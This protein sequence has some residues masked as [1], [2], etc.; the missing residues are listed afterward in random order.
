MSSK[1]A[2]K[3]NNATAVKDK[4]GNY[5]LILPAIILGYIPLIIHTYQYDPG[6][7]E[8]S[9]FDSGQVVD[10]YLASKMFIYIP[11]GLVM[12]CIFFLYK[13]IREEKFVFDKMLIPLY[14]YAAFVL[15]SGF[16]SPYKMQAWGGSFE[17][18]ESVPV[19]LIY[20]F[21]AIYVYS[22]A[23]SKAD[24]NLLWKVASPGIFIE[25]LISALQYFDLD[26]FKTSFAKHLYLSPIYWSQ[27]DTMT[28]GQYRTSYGT[29]Y[30]PDFLPA[31]HAVVISLA[32]AAFFMVEKP[33]DE[34]QAALSGKGGFMTEKRRY[35]FERIYNAVILGL[36]IISLIGSDTASGKIVLVVVVLV[37]IVGELITDVKHVV[38]LLV[39][40]AL[41]I[42]A[43][44]GAAASPTAIGE[45]LRPY[46]FG[47]DYIN[48]VYM[49]AMHNNKDDVDFEISCFDKIYTFHSTFSP[50]TGAV[51]LTCDEP[52]GSNMVIGALPENPAVI[53][54]QST[55]NENFIVDVAPYYSPQQVDALGN[56]T[57]PSYGGISITLG[58]KYWYFVLTENGYMYYTF[59]D[60]LE[61]FPN[62]V[63]Y[64][65]FFD[66]DLLHHRGSLWNYTIPL[67]GKHIILGSGANTYVRE[68]PQNDY[69]F[70]GNLHSLDVKP[71][72]SFL[73]QW[74]ENGFVAMLALVV[75]L[76]WQVA[77][78]L[79]LLV[80]HFENENWKKGGCFRILAVS[81]LA[82]YAGVILSWLAND[83]NICTSPVVWIAF[84]IAMVCIRDGQE[85]KTAEK[86]AASASK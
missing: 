40:G 41:V 35:L 65:R 7:S 75:F 52:D 49:N 19:V 47:E 80:T 1:V 78:L 23:R 39:V 18:F 54:A 42:G 10:V 36:S 73:Q 84:G 11:V 27:I 66:Q 86:N 15:I 58:V 4:T 57:Q 45:K 62:D 46:L 28:V 17:M 24:L 21:S 3:N 20:V 77:A 56:E 34:V 72:C 69:L 61:D 44:V 81:C 76:I 50:E 43:V 37:L 9:W 63:P 55:L 70:E 71:H 51:T 14:V 59:R 12:V 6:M 2:K 38:I 64:V 5:L 60:R 26:F 32:V 85:T 22:L 29:L 79:R 25:C 8:F 48:D 67:L 68:Y 30:N 33:R 31:Y 16:A 74:V 13:W 53:R 83:S 82:M